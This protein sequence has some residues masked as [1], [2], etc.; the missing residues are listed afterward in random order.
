MDARRRTK[1]ITTLEE[2]LIKAAENLRSKASELP[3]GLERDKLLKKAREFEVQVLINELLAP[4]PP[5]ERNSL[6]P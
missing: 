4:P 3:P 6:D 1:Q 5:P 2:R